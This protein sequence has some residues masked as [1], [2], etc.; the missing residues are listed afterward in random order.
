LQ[1]GTTSASDFSEIVDTRVSGLWALDLHTGRMLWR[2]PE[3]GITAPVPVAG[4]LMIGTTR[5]GLFLLPP[6]D[7][8]PMDGFDLGTGFSQ[9]PASFGNRAY[10]PLERRHVPR[11]ASRA[12]RRPQARRE[13][14]PLLC[15]RCGAPLSEEARRATSTCA[16]CGAN[17]SARLRVW[18]S[19]E[20][21]VANAHT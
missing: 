12:A 9:T 16:Y 11:R 8:R 7:G 14:S 17:L 3:G 10:V 2:I 21:G 20:W 15:T 4:A 18:G 13:M 19:S 1:V 6:V 5:Y